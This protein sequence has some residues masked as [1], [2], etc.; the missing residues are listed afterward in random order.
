LIKNEKYK[1]HIVKALKIQ[2]FSYT[3]NLNDHPEHLFGRKFD[4]DS[5]DGDVPPFYVSF[6]VH[7]PIIHNEMLDSGES[8]NLMPKFIM[9]KLGSGITRPYKYL[10]SF[11]SIKA[12]CLGLIKDLVFSLSQITSKSIVMDI[13]IVDIPP[14]LGM[15]VSRS[16]ATKLKHA[17]QM[18]MSY[19]TIHVFGHPRRLYRETL[20]KYMV[21]GK[22][23]PNNHPI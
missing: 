9:D 13:V 17:L 11:D 16:W 3:I 8:H 7:D 1:I 20:M 5:Q 19:A 10:F 12:K 21:G 2:D 18:D 15:I 4:G 14:N 22:E 6:N 23:R